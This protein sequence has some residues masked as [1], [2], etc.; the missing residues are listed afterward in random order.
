MIRWFQL[1]NDQ[2]R[3]TEYHTVLN[4]LYRVGSV[5]AFPSPVGETLD[6]VKQKLIRCSYEN[7][8]REG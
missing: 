3:D 7:W 4:D 5:E 6:G 2:Q 1:L 8:L